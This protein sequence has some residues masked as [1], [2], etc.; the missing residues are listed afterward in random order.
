MQNN[1][2]NKGKTVQ[3]QLIKKSSNNKCKTVPATKE[4]QFQQQLVYLEA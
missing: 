1:Y 2:S 3:Q 4:K